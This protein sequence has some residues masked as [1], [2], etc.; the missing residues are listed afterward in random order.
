MQFWLTVESFKDPLES[1]DSMTSDSETDPV[2]DTLPSTT[3]KEDMKMITNLYFSESNAAVVSPAQTALSILTQKYVDAIRTYAETSDASPK[4]ERKARRSVMLAQRQVERVMD[5]DFEEFQRSDLWFRAV[6]DLQPKAEKLGVTPTPEALPF[7]APAL[8]TTHSSSSNSGLFATLVQGFSSDGNRSA[9]LL[10]GPK[11]SALSGLSRADSSSPEFTSTSNVGARRHPSF[12]RMVPPNSRTV[13]GQTMNPPA[14]NLEI[15]MSPSTGDENTTRAP[16]F[17]EGE[18]G[19]LIS[20]DAEEA[21][22]MEAIQAAVTDIIASENRDVMSTS[23]LHRQPTLHI[24]EKRASEDSLDQAADKGDRQSV[25]SGLRR[26]GIF[27]DVYDLP[28]DDAGEQ[29]VEDD[30]ASFGTG[31]FEPAAPGDLQLAHEIDR[32]SEKISHL[33]SQDGILDALIRKAELTGDTAELKLLRRSKS[34]LERELRQLRFQK[35]QYEQ[36]DSLNRLVAGHT[37]AA[38]VN[39]T[40]GEEDGKSVVRYLIEVQQLD[41]NGT[42][43]SGWVVARRYSEFLVMH[44]R[45]RDKYLAVRNLEFPG[46]K[47]ITTLSS[48]MMDQRR[49]ALE[50]YL[51]V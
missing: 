38:I 22:R 14:N 29:A 43:A 7:T 45:L 32:I 10:S 11:A 33:E 15:L 12:S 2:S 26:K 20:A 39:A 5:H 49:V 51:Q 19:R 27:D 41:Y 25:R 46:K 28:D 9:P 21:Q 37:R 16:L 17:D 23:D 48:S 47:L 6:A 1:V 44:Q 35:V 8:Q 31:N 3:L 30:D 4:E 24:P 42:F 50:K 18:D 13:S 40:T 36:Q 34:A